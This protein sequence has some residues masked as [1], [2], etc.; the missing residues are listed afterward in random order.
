[1]ER[2]NGLLT[3]HADA[4]RF[5]SRLA[6]SD[7]DRRP[8]SSTPLLRQ[9]ESE[10]QRRQ[11]RDGHLNPLINLVIGVHRFQNEQFDNF[12]GHLFCHWNIV[13]IEY[14]LVD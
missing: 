8:G 3:D 13:V 4:S 12:K 1:M 7:N 9:E 14:L 10:H 2:K 11:G 6:G 5:S